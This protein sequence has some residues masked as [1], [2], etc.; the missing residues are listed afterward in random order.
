LAGALGSG[1]LVASLIATGLANIAVGSS[2]RLAPVF[3]LRALAGLAMAGFV[4]LAFEWMNGQTPPARRPMA[5]LG[6]TAMMGATL[7]PLIGG[8]RGA[9]RKRRDLLGAGNGAG[10]RR[11]RNGGVDAAPSALI[12]H[13]RAVYLSALQ[14]WHKRRILRTQQ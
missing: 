10:D 14:C 8:C 12:E 11:R 1:A 2:A 7:Q 4:P 13:S 5:G 3:V 9:R 6:S